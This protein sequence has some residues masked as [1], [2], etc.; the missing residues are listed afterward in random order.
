[1]ENSTTIGKDYNLQWTYGTVVETGKNMETKISGGGGGGAT[2]GGYG[3][4]T[5]TR[6]RSE[7]I[8]HDQIFLVDE[9]QQEH[10][11]QLKHMNV[12]CRNGNALSVFQ[13]IKEGRNRGSYI[14]VYNHTTGQVFS[15]KGML[16]MV[17]RRN[18]WLV[19]ALMIAA[20]FL[21]SVGYL[22]YYLILILPVAW[23]LEGYI[24]ANKFLKETDFRQF[25]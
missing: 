25:K 22:F 24:T 20:V 23:F 13:A 15:H 7:T 3:A 8:I 11:F 4:S 10:S 19:L 9:N 16:Q 18:G 14:I 17:F 2:F 6:I 1:M 21:G 5:A 12:A